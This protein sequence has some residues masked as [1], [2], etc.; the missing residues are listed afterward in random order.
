MTDYFGAH[1]GRRPPTSRSGRTPVWAQDQADGRPAQPAVPWRSWEPSP[2]APQR[3]RGPVKAW[4]LAISLLAVFVAVVMTGGSDV[5]PLAAAAGREPWDRPAIGRDPDRPTPGVE[6][7][8]SPRGAPAAGTTPSSAFRFLST[9]ENSDDPVAYD[10]CRPVHV[11][12]NG[13][14][15]EG[16]NEV[17]AA[18]VAKVASA[19]GLRFVWD[20]P[21]DE[22]PSDDREAYQPDRYG[23]RWAPV[24]IGWETDNLN[25]DMAADVVGLAGSRSLSFPGRPSVYLTG[26]IELDARQL[27]EV[28]AR[29]EG[30]A[31]ARAIVQHEL[32]HV[33]GLGH[34]DDPS[35]IMFP[36]G[37]LGVRDFGP[38]DLTGLAALGRGACVPEL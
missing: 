10:P 27:A 16:G 4:L 19:T 23:D 21:T 6:A 1:P 26:Q 13:L 33:V 7:E 24:L 34:V 18:A 12:V 14:A 22:L 20:A 37:R 11:T 25:P 38:G 32:A 8:G 36:E 30:V 9:Q 31:E 17:L 28:L 2:P 29:P 5:G 3:S 35:Q 15:P